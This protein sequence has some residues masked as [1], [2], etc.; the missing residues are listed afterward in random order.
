MRW[1]VPP[2][3]R[4]LIPL[5]AQA[6]EWPDDLDLTDAPELVRVLASTG[7][8]MEQE[9]AV[10][11]PRFEAAMVAALEDALRAREEASALA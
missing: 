1:L 10:L 4:E 8:W 6:R 3:W 2:F 5:H 9:R 7:Q 11:D